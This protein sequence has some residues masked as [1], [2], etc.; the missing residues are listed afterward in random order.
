[1]TMLMI[2]PIKSVGMGSCS[3][4][5]KRIKSFINHAQASIFVVN[6]N[7][8]LPDI[9]VFPLFRYIYAWNGRINIRNR[10]DN[11]TLNNTSI[12]FLQ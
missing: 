10:A 7:L 9:M 11:A 5:T 2:C 4:A 8:K 12:L 3:F 1:M 6:E